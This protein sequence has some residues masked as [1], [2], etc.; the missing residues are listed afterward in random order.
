MVI[1]M[2]V[3][4]ALVVAVVMAVAVAVTVAMTAAVAMTA[5][6]AVHLT[7]D[8]AA[9]AGESVWLAVLSRV[10]WM[11]AAAAVETVCRAIAAGGVA[12]GGVL[13]LSGQAST[14]RTRPHQCLWVRVW[15]GLW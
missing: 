11:E 13:H 3:M 5:V 1:A 15:S 6:V 9:H 7:A 8:V 2:A 4:V 12:C 14:E 10:V